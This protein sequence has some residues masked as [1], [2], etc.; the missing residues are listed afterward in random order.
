MTRI[1]H[2]RLRKSSFVILADQIL[3]PGDTIAIPCT[4]MTKFVNPSRCSSIINQ[5]SINL[6]IHPSIRLSIHHDIWLY[7]YIP[8]GKLSHG[9]GKSPFF[10]GKSTINQTAMFNSYASLPEGENMGLLLGLPLVNCP[11]SMETHHF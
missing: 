8:S 6:S 9:C 4:D 10:I 7:I 11:I 5:S 1:H 3:Y 2:H